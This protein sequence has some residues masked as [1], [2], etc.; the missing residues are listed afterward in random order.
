MNFNLNDFIKNCNKTL[1]NYLHLLSNSGLSEAEI[2]LRKRL[3]VLF[4]RE[5]FINNNTKYYRSQFNVNFFGRFFSEKLQKSNSE[6]FQFSFSKLQSILKDYFDYLKTQRI[7]SRKLHQNIIRNLDAKQAVINKKNESNN[8]LNSYSFQEEREDFSKEVFDKMLKKCDKWV[9]EF[10][11][12]DYFK[13]LTNEEKKYMDFIISSFFQYLYIYFLKTPEQIDEEDLEEMCLFILPRKITAED[14]YF[15]AIVP[16]L[17][18]FFKF[19]ENKGIIHNA[20]ELNTKL[21]GMREKIMEE[22]RNPNNWGISKFLLNSAKA[23]GINIYDERELNAYFNVL[24]ELNL[25]LQNIKDQEFLTIEDVEDLKTSEIIKKLR[26]F[27]ITFDRKQFI[28]DTRRMFS[29]FEILKEWKD[30]NFI[31]D[32]LGN[33]YFICLAIIVLWNRLSPGLANREQIISQI[34]EGYGLIKDHEIVKGCKLWLQV[35]EL[36]KGRIQPEMSS[37]EDLEKLFSW[38]TSIY[39]WTLDLSVELYNAGV[40]ANKAFFLKRIRFCKEILKYFPKSD[41]SYLQNIMMDLA[42]T[43]FLLGLIDLGDKMY[44]I[45]VKKFPSFTFGYIRWGDQYAGIYNY[46]MELFNPEKALSIY[47]MGLKNGREDIKILKNH[48]EELL[49]LKK[50]LPFKEKMLSDFKA[51]LSKKNLSQKNHEKKVKHVEFFLDFALFIY[52]IDDLKS[53]AEY[54]P[55]IIL[56]FLASWSIE[57]LNLSKTSQKELIR[58][59]KYYFMYLFNIIPFSDEEMERIKKLLNATEYYLKRLNEYKEL[60]E[61]IATNKLKIDALLK[62]RELYTKWQ[63]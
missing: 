37:I 35:W 4:L 60:K 26:T 30:K 2:K 25:V 11:Q 57:Y 33:L 24:N 52:D 61:L 39:D 53:L 16:V 23:A 28:E 59:I 6:F 42:E 58:N 40:E 27:G 63:D 5:Y 20:N 44:R 43:Y 3:I 17:T 8:D 21:N 50:A 55:D 31:K 54:S 49:F 22:V 32:D 51:F 10:I 13:N 12:T 18:G 36:I 41:D 7:L 62:W 45:L 46:N 34:I 15:K 47:K 1:P 29:I 48:I 19:L 56:E 38:T 9:E 14:S